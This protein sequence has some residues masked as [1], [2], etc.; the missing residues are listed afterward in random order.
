MTDKKS[1]LEEN[2]MA[3]KIIMGGQKYHDRQKHLWQDENIRAGI[4][5]CQQENDKADNKIMGG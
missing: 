4:N 3:D 5:R 2:F 1:W